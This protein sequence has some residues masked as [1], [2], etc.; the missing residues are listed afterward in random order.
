MIEEFREYF[1]YDDGKLL[2][3]K[4]KGSRGQIGNRFG[5]LE[6]SGYR[7]GMFNKKMYREHQIIF[8][9]HYGNIPE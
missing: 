8:A 9:L 7:H 6:P 5:S 4:A 2:W 1:Y 3:K